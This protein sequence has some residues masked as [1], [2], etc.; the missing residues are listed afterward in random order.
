MSLKNL[1]DVLDK[2]VIDGQVHCVTAAVTDADHIRFQGAAGLV[3]EDTQFWIAS[4]TKPI[5]SVAALQLVEQDKLSLDEPLERLLPALKDLQ[6]IE[7]GVLRP[8]LQKI[9]LKHLLTH[10][11]G[12]SYPFTSTEIAAWEKTQNNPAALGSLESLKLPLLFEPGTR[13]EYGV[14]TDWVGL[15]VEAASGMSLAEYFAAYIFGPLGMS[16]TGFLPSPLRAPLHIRRKDGTLS[17]QPLKP[18]TSPEFFSG[19]GGLYSTCTD[20]L[21]FLRIFL[22]SGSGIISSASVKALT[23][24]QIGKLLAGKLPSANPNF[25]NN[26]D[27]TQGIDTQWTLGFLLFPTDGPFG[28]HAGSVSWEGAANTYFWIDPEST[29]AA[30]IMMQILPLGDQQCVRT[31][32]RFEQA[33]Y[34]E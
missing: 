3:G 26:A 8:A 25:A 10:T 24:N 20:Y 9:T 18:E 12:F 27:P 17:L 7:N 13:W 1:Q 32:T 30:V 11:S 14:S 19:G 2:A 6:I 22:N 33:V 16:N 28:R 5:T 23:I 21:K 29:L 4:M 31:V 34:T 15:A